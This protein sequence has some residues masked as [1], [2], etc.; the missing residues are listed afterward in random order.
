MKIERFAIGPIRTN[1]YLVSNEDTKEAV[2]V[3]PA[4]C[5]EYL[6]SHIRREQIQPKAILLTHGHFDHIL[7]LDGFLKEWD[8]PVYVQE[9]E[10]DTMTNVRL[11]HTNAVIPSG[12]T[13]SDAVYLKDGQKIEAAGFVFEV[14]HTPGHTT[15]SCCYYAEA[16]QVLFSGDTLF[17]ESV[18]RTDFENSRPAM[19]GASIRE[20]LFVLPD[21]TRVLPG[22]DDETSIGHEKQ[23][24]PYV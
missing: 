7:G 3:D 20:K 13:F 21:D 22:H 19:I 15:G 6:V 10:K 8:M 18:G 4:D 5:P 9:E 17:L 14:L 12:Y 16:E 24:N 1:C 2:L 23:Y 11:N